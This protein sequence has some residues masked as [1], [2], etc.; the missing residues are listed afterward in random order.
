MELARL[1]KRI[2]FLSSEELNEG[3]ELLRRVFR[4][5]NSSE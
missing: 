2:S 5:R 3:G 4:R 1:V